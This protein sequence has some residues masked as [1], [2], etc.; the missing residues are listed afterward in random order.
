MQTY[1]L[2][3]SNQLYEIENQIMDKN[4]KSIMVLIADSTDFDTNFLINELNKFE[5]PFFGGIFPEII[6]EN[7][8]KKQGALIILLDFEV[9]NFVVNLDQK[10][11]INLQIEN[12]A[13]Q[14]DDEKKSIWIYI[15]FLTKN[16]NYFIETLYEELGFL[17]TYVGA[18][19]GSLNFKQMPCVFNNS[20]IYQNAAVLAF[21]KKEFS[22]GVNHGWKT[23]SEKL[24]VTEAFENTI[25]SINWKP[26][27]EVY[28]KIVEEHSNQKFT[29]DNFFEIAKSYP[30]GVLKI[31]GDIIVRDPIIMEN[32]KLIIVDQ[33]NEGEFIQVLYGDL[34]SLID[35]ANDSNKSAENSNNKNKFC[36]DCISRALYMG[37]NFDKEI[38]VINNGGLLNGILSI[39]EIVN[40]NNS[41]LEIYNKTT[42]VITW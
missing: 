40:Q 9:E 41:F 20:G 21:A 13:N 5:K 12:I 34:Q 18:G 2:K 33:I 42:V 30:L 4:T 8:Q 39:G 3:N 11:T 19:A 22:V 38:Q 24:Q 7:H 37:D 32:Q 28:S 14:I 17:Y 26:A 29:N 31:D 15:D 27:A 25:I 23:F 35:G 36:I 1:F 10:E 6:F 16:K